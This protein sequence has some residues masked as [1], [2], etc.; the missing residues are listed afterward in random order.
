MIIFSREITDYISRDNFKKLI[1][2][3]SAFPV[4]KPKGDYKTPLGYKINI[5]LFDII[6]DFL[7]NYKMVIAVDGH[8]RHISYIDA[9]GHYHVIIDKPFVDFIHDVFKKED[10]ERRID[11]LVNEMLK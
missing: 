4:D 8:I 3:L 9:L 1:K 10:L 7:S 11:L 5:Y 2:I 6:Q